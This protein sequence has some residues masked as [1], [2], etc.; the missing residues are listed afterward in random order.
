[1]S[2]GSSTESYPAFARIGLR[3]NPGKNLNQVTCP[4]PPGFAARRTDRYSTAREGPRPTS[5]LLASRPHAEAEVDDDP[6]RM[7]ATVTDNSYLDML[8]LWLL[9]QLEQDIG[10]I[11]QQ[12]GAPPH[13]QLDVKNEMNTRLPRRWIGR[14]SREDL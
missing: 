8:Q 13:Y 9:P 4:G 3:K 14:A 5:R 6:T 2:P 1:M 11:F 10:I 12:G 7:E